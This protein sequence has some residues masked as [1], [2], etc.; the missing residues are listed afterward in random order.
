MTNILLSRHDIGKRWCEKDL[1]KY[2]KKGGKVAVVAF[3]F[4]ESE[5][6]TKEDWD[7]YYGVNGTFSAAIEKS[8][9]H[10]GIGAKDVEYVNYFRDTP[11]SAKN[12]VQNA[13][14]LYFPGG[15]A[16]KIMTRVIELGLYGVIENHRGI[17]IGFGAGAQVQLANYRVMSGGKML[18]SLGFRFADG[19]DV[20][21]DYKSDETQNY[22]ISRAVSERGLPVYAIGE[23]GAVI[24]ED[25]VMNLVGDVRCF[26]KRE[27]V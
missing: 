4:R 23:E 10:Y 15:A 27:A 26:Q 6:A 11:S 14:I 2:I 19:F 8:F 17:V 16:D 22:Y 24:V 25:G 3:S 20:E 5:I 21:T 12:K 9:G 7:R 18:Y 13:D 1:K